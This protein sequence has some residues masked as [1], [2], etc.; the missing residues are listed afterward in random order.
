MVMTT[1]LRIL[2]LWMSLAFP[3]PSR[4]NP[5]GTCDLLLEN[6]HRLLEVRTQKL[7]V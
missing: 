5:S 2:S 7:N 1:F 3:P 4:H 6:L